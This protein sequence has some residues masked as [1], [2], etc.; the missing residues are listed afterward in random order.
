MIKN[1]KLIIFLKILNQTAPVANPIAKRSYCRI[2]GREEV[3]DGEYR[4]NQKLISEFLGTALFI[5]GV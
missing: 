5:W 1:L 4:L 2:Y 3:F